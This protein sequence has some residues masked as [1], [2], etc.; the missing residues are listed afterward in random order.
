MTRTAAT[1]AAIMIPTCCTIPTAV[2]TESSEKTMSRA[3][4]CRRTEP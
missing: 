1:T 2:I 3:M 4:I